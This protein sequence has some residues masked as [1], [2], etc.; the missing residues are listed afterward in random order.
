MYVDY[1]LEDSENIPGFDAEMIET[2][3]DMTIDEKKVYLENE[4]FAFR[5]TADV[6]TGELEEL[7]KQDKI[8]RWEERWRKRASLNKRAM[9]S[10]EEVEESLKRALGE[11]EI[12]DFEEYDT[13][14]TFKTNE[15]EYRWIINEDTAYEM[16]VER[17]REDLD[18]SPDY[19]S[20]D[21]LQGHVDEEAWLED[22]RS[23][24]EN[25]V[26][27][28]PESYTTFIDDEE[29]AENSWARGLQRA[30]PCGPLRL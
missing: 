12:F 3:G 2:L 19:F 11:E 5:E 6:D 7:K 27:E 13:N 17:V 29:P 25:M 16:A 15:Y 24:L 20:Q 14:G 1:L 28:S 30:R 9:L 8:R 26:S 18:N 22:L 10:P 21:W 23:D 4:G